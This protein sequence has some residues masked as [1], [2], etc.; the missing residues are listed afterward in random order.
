MSVYIGFYYGDTS[1]INYTLH[2]DEG[3]AHARLRTGGHCWNG[4]R[5]FDFGRLPAARRHGAPR[6]KEAAEDESEDPDIAKVETLSN[7]TPLPRQPNTP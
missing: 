3:P 4:S 1:N 5:E 2:E 7:P 6:R